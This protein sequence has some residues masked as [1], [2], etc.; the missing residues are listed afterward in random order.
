MMPVLNPGQL[1]RRSTDGR[2]GAITWADATSFYVKYE[3]NDAEYFY[4]THSIGV[5]VDLYSKDD[6]WIEEFVV[7]L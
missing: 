4:S 5:R 1:V 3:C 7:R 2:F 6:D